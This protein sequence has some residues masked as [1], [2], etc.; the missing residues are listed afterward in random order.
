MERSDHITCPVSQC[1]FQGTLSQV[2]HHI[3]DHD[4]DTHTWPALGYQHSGEFRESH[5]SSPNTNDPSVDSPSSR[6]EQQT[7]HKK[8]LEEIAGVGNKRAIAFKEAGY[9]TS[10]E[11]AQ[12]SISELSE[13]PLI[14]DSL[15]R[16]VR[17]MAREECSYSDTFIKRL[18]DSLETDRGAVA[19]AYSDLARVSVPPKDAE[20]TLK[21]LFDTDSDDSVM[22]LSEYSVRFRHFL[23]QEGFER[24][25]DVAEA[26][27]DELTGAPYIGEA[28][29]KNIRNKACEKQEK[30]TDVSAGRSTSE[31][32][33][34]DSATAEDGKT[35]NENSELTDTGE[36]EKSP[37]NRMFPEKMKS[38]DQWLLW[39]ETDDGRKVPRAPWGTGDPLQYVS[40]LD[41]SNW[42]PFDEAI[43][44]QSKLPQNFEL[45]Y[46]L[47]REDEIVFLDLD[48]VVNDGEPSPEARTI[49]ERAKSYTAVSTSGTGLHI[50]VHGSLSE[51]IKSLTGPIDDDGDQSLEVY[52]R[53]R[54]IAVTGQHLDG[55]RTEITTG[56][57]LLNELEK[58]YA[59][60]SSDT[61]DRTITE[62][63][64]TRDELRDIETT[65]DIQ[66]VFDA[67]SQTRPSDIR[68]RSTQTK[69]H[70]DGTY[71]YD[72]S[73]V[74]SESG[75]RLG[76]L[77]DLWI[78]RKG[79]IALDAL[80]LVALEEGIIT[81]ERAYPEGS[82]FWEAVE[83]L[84]DR[85]AHIP[86]FE[87]SGEQI[88]ESVDEGS[89]A[90]IDKW[91][92]AK[93]INYGDRVRGYLHPYD[94]DYQERLA[95]D[96]TPTLI[97]TAEALHLSTP[98]T[99]RAAEL[100]AKGHATGI[101]P[102]AAHESTLGA[103]LRIATIE[104]NTPRPL[105][106]IS[107]T[108]NV[109]AKS[110]RKKFHRIIKETGL[111]KELDTADFIVDPVDY[112]PYM[113]QQL[114]LDQDN[115]ISES[116]R[117][118]LNEA[119]LDGSS[120]PMS[121]VAAAF[122]VAMKNSDDHSITQKDVANVARVS[123]VTIRNNYPKYTTQ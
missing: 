49:I 51:G 78:Y 50:F 69:E 5:T 91:E 2:I 46:A 61:P 103:A 3:T 54:F 68:M 64:R 47:T 45:A 39:K 115:S 26:S 116:V 38:N 105:A 36:A 111:S 16:C 67:I 90:E 14:S 77:D 11:I 52:D 96:L 13:V 106:E 9:E 59:S 10:E 6:P 8:Q 30:D 107:D 79:M 118:L 63:E 100:Y 93:R 72:P 92:V 82:D 20:Q 99:Y 121:E 104:A 71:S 85:G 108:L 17:V 27:I 114:E 109:G 55:T 81:D 65:S 97:E 37:S 34:D 21:M 31:R 83:T 110:I 18:S 62:P 48:D 86:Q 101:V 22:L 87:S 23:F 41:P 113:S 80:Q 58:E 24:L 43:Q 84:R 102:G 32:P 123:E 70:G 19:D 73:W 42:V 98:V 40:A 66:D 94:Q 7:D 95:L 89:G 44:W 112:V 122:Y 76:V 119:D 28:L 35:G 15:A 4:A 75:T 25:S 117:N 53:N 29:A 120:N 88:T 60:I 74:H 1:S 57:S 12:A 56:S 33:T